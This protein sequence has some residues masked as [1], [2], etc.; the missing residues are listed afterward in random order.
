[1]PVEEEE[2]EVLIFKGIIKPRVSQSKETRT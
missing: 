1:V 2:E